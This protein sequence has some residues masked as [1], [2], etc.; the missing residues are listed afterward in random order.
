MIEVSRDGTAFCDGGDNRHLATAFEALGDVDPKD[1]GQHLR[2]R[3]VFRELRIAA[4]VH[5]LKALLDVGLQ[6]DVPAV[7][8]VRGE[9]TAP[10]HQMRSGWRNERREFFQEFARREPQVSRP[11]RPFRL[12]PEFD[13]SIGGDLQ[14]LIGQGVCAGG[15]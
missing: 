6:R 5:K 4:V 13:V 9:D 7:R 15:D 10:S 8:G 14:T 11:I 3:V 1:S 12:E 2:P